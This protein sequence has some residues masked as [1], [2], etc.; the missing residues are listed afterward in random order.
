MA[1]VVFGSLFYWPDWAIKYHARMMAKMLHG[2]KPDYSNLIT[3]YYLI[4]TELDLCIAAMGIKLYYTQKQ[5]LPDS[6]VD[7][8]PAY[9][10]EVPLDPFNQFQPLKY[11]RNGRA[12]T[13]YSFG[14]DKKDDLGELDL[15]TPT[16]LPHGALISE[17]R[18]GDLVIAIRD[19]H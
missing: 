16:A 13:V 2:T 18:K 11:R 19:G 12:W 9:M 17:T 1:H 15:D 8:V 3:Q 14:P 10:T 7:L 6:L 4:N 5:Q